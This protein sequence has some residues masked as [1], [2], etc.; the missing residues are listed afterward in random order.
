VPFQ[1][2]EKVF[3]KAAGRAVGIDLP[4]AKVLAGPLLDKILAEQHTF[5]STMLQDNNYLGGTSDGWRKTYSQSGA[6]MMNFIALPGS[7]ANHSR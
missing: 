6:S 2:S 7:R 4:S 3:V 5:T 1:S